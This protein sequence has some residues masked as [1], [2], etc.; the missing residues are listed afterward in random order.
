VGLGALDL[1]EVL[2]DPAV[3]VHHAR[4]GPDMPEFL[5]T[6]AVVGTKFT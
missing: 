5:D 6:V 3:H 1:V 4:A 2:G